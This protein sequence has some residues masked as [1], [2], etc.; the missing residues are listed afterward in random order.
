MSLSQKIIFDFWSFVIFYA[1]KIIKKYTVICML[2]EMRSISK[3]PDKP[4]SYHHVL[5]HNFNIITIFLVKHFKIYQ[6]YNKIIRKFH[7]F[8]ITTFENIAYIF[9]YKAKYYT[10]KSSNQRFHIILLCLRQ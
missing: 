7:Y 8:F 5:F 2:P 10:N 4:L 9:K 1:F 6:K 3:N